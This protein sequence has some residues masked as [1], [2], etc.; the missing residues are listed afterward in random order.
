MGKCVT[1]LHFS[2]DNLELQRSPSKAG[3][4]VE[5]V[6]TFMDSASMEM[7][8]YLLNFRVSKVTE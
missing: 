5:Q 8:P 4:K 1:R 3:Q 6:E 2:Q 7:L